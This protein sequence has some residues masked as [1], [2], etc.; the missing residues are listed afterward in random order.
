MNDVNPTS[1]PLLKDLKLRRVLNVKLFNA[2]IYCRLVGK[3][4]YLFNNQPNLLFQEFL[5]CTCMTQGNHIGR[6]LNMFYGISREL[7][8]LGLFMGKMKA[9]LS[10]AT[11]MQITRETMKM[12]TN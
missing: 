7:P 1:I 11:L 4:I 10:W 12:T 9:Q 6:L 5:A 8:I 3:L 2:S